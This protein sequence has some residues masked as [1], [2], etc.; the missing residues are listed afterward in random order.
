MS[1][2]E[3]LFWAL[4]IHNLLKFSR[5]SHET[6]TGS[7]QKP[8]ASKATQAGRTAQV[9]LALKSVPFLL[10]QTTFLRAAA[11]CRFLEKCS[12]PLIHP[13]RPSPGPHGFNYCSAMIKNLLIA[14]RTAPASLFFILMFFCFFFCVYFSRQTLIILVR[15]PKTWRYFNWDHTAFID[16]FRG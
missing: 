2:F 7:E 3:T 8:Q 9:C 14:R 1:T 12:I 13:S 5:Y 10:H 15:S 6:K 16:Y 11:V 4:Y